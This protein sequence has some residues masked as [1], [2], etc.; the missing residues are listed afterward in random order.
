[1]EMVVEIMAVVMEIHIL[2]KVRQLLNG[3]IDAFKLQ[4][5]NALNNETLFNNTKTYLQNLHD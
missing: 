4:H 2:I 5:F 1:M 3:G